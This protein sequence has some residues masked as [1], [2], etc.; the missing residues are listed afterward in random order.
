[1]EAIK[2][3][4]D[5]L[6][7]ATDVDQ[8]ERLK[9]ELRRHPNLYFQAIYTAL[10]HNPSL[11]LNPAEFTQLQIEHRI[12]NAEFELLDL[13]QLASLQNGLRVAVFCMPKSGS[14]FT[15]AAINHA[16]GLPYLSLTTFT[17][18]ASNFGMNGREQ[19]IDDF[20]TLVAAFRGRGS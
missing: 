16:L 8:Q 13:R 15:R 18:L 6:A 2:T 12:K 14:S 4:L 10:V 19:E 3:V 17:P 7:V 20:A 5:Q 11:S 1:M 9:A